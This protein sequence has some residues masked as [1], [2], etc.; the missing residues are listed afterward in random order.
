MKSVVFLLL[1]FGFLALVH[2]R[3]HTDSFR[4]QS[5]LDSHEQISRYLDQD[6]HP[7]RSNDT[8]FASSIGD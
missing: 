3:I 4:H 1:M 6:S 8:N 5:K 2:A 7:D